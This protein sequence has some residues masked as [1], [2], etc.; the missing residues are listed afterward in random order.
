[1]D[2][3]AGILAQ[4]FERSM[5][6]GPEWRVEDVWFEGRDGAPDELHVRVGR[7]PVFDSL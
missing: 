5:G 7:V 2:A 1:M 3:Q 4:P 6:L